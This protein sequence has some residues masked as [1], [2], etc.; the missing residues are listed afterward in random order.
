MSKDIG[1]LLT[2]K[3]G[4]AFTSSRMVA[5]KFNKNHRDVLRAIRSIV[6]NPKQSE[7][8]ADFNLRNYAQVVFTTSK[9]QKY[10]EYHM[11][12]DGFS[13][14]AMGFT[15][16]EVRQWKI[17][18]TN[19]FNAMEEELLRIKLQ[20]KDTEWKALREQSKLTRRNETDVIQKFVEYAKKQGSKNAEK[21]YLHYTNLTYKA[22]NI[23]AKAS[24]GIT[25]A[26]R[27][28]LDKMEISQLEYAERIATHWIAKGMEQGKD[29]HDIYALVREKVIETMAIT[30][31]P[32]SKVSE[33]IDENISKPKTKK[34]KKILTN[35]K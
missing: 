28:M 17:K 7:L 33:A 10:K 9:G 8:E 2:V 21:Y 31:M 22:L 5:E 11:T 13:V 15:G 30:F 19:A 27:D 16:S 1:S 29:Y 24:E 34:P 4:G 14:L 23:V 32:L 25:T 26:Y 6:E 20:N 3:K 12:R 18:F 35:V